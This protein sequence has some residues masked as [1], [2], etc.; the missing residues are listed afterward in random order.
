MEGVEERISEIQKASNEL[1]SL[2]LGIKECI[3]DRVKSKDDLRAYLINEGFVYDNE[4]GVYKK[5]SSI[6]RLIDTFPIGVINGEGLENNKFVI[7][8]YK[9]GN[10]LAC[11]PLDNVS[12]YQRF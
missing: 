9:R 2:I 10:Y 1:K 6:V 5:E 7:F 11:L 3:G 12:R 8:N 4:S